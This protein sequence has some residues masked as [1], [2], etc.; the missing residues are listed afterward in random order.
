LNLQGDS[1]LEERYQII[2]NQETVLKE[3]LKETKK[4]LE[5]LRSKKEYYQKQL[6]SIEK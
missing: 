5:H 1:T 3:Q 2:C 4:S 6:K